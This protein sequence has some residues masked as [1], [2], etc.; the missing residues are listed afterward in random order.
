MNK[1]EMLVAAIEN[2]TVIDHIPSEKTYQ[3]AQLLNLD[4]LSSTV[5]IGYNY[6]SK[7]LGKKGIIK[8]EDKW[9]TDE[10]ISR[11]SVVAP[12]IV[13][14]IIRDY[15]VVEKKTVCTPD[16]IKGIVKCNNPKC[17]TNN[18]P[19]PTYFHVTNGILTCHYCEKEQDINKVEL[20]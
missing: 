13:L 16:E 3:V 4:K 11:L 8:V 9:F 1:N 14:N 2:G 12:N 18:E 19:M 7:K 5:T 10:E 17:I 6:R 15:E 20:V